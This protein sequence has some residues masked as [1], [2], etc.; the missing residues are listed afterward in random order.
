MTDTPKKKPS[1]WGKGKTDPDTWWPQGCKSPNPTGRP[2]GSKSRHTLWKE[3]SEKKI[4]VTF[5]GESK[6]MTKQE[7]AYHQ[8]AQKAAAG[9]LKAIAMLLSLDE[10]FDPGETIPPTNA[11]S[12]ADFATLEAWLAFMEKFKALKPGG[13][14][15]G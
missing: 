9:D 15:D 11:E 12:A 3:A 7:L 5:D 1:N 6:Q 2:K 14:D 4:T 8:L 10:K 13:D